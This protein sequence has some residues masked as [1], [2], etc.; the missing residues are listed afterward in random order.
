MVKNERNEWI[1][2]AKASQKIGKNSKYFSNL[3]GRRPEYFK[4]VHLK[5]LGTAYVMK[6]SNIPKILKRIKKGGVR[7][8]DR[9]IKRTKVRAI[10][11]LSPRIL[12]YTIL[13]RC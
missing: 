9:P 11:P 8:V 6:E 7:L 2:L 12:Y 3:L 10:L 13:W 1:T 4:G 5:K